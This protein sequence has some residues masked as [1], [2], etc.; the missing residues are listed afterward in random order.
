MPQKP[1]T[2]LV[3]FLLLTCSK[4]LS[5]L[6]N[7]TGAVLSTPAEFKN[8]PHLN[9]SQQQATALP[10]DTAFYLNTPGIGDQGKIGSCV[11]W[12]IAYTFL[13]TVYFGSENSGWDNSKILSPEFLYNLGLFHQQAEKTQPDY[14][15]VRQSVAIA[16][17]TARR[18]DLQPKLD[19]DAGINIIKALMEFHNTGVCT[20]QSMPYDTNCHV[21]PLP[22]QM[23][24][25]RRYKIPDVLAVD[26]TNVQVLKYV[27]YKS[28]APIIVGYNVTTSF[29][30][31]WYDN[32]AA[33]VWKTNDS[34]PV[35]GHCVCIIGY[36]DK[37]KMF[38]VQNQWGSK[39]GDKGFFWV[40]YDLIRSGCFEETYC[41][42][43]NL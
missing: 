41:L 27:L 18:I 4:G 20:M 15:N 19:C 30:T 35:E 6:H 3:I 36:S 2:H 32:R 17:E 25:A 33:G 16:L 39:N 43:R 34:K 23:D 13:S 5:Q 29:T 21:L 38:K 10:M 12:G 8:Y 31:M 14:S 40:T 26:P 37:R 9:I 28:K 11:G 7:G 42:N 24:E 22:A 1:S